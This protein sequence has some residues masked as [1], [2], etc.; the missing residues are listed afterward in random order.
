MVSAAQ[1]ES[2]IRKVLSFYHSQAREVEQNLQQ[3]GKTYDDVQQQVSARTSEA[4]KLQLVDSQ[5]QKLQQAGEHVSNLL[6][7]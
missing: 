6:Q 1:L 4:H 3:L 7:V 5:I 2:E